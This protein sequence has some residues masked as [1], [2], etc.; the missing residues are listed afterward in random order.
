MLANPSN[1]PTPSHP[2]N[3]LPRVQ[4]R[5]VQAGERR[6]DRFPTIPQRHQWLECA[7][8]H[9]SHQLVLRTILLFKAPVVDEE[10]FDSYV[11]VD[12]VVHVAHAVVLLHGQLVLRDGAAD[13]DSAP[14]ICHAN[15]GLE[16]LA[17]NVLERAIETAGAYLR[18]RFAQVCGHVR[19]VVTVEDGIGAE[20]SQQTQLIAGPRRR[21]HLDTALLEELDGHRAHRAGCTRYV[22]H[23]AGLRFANVLDAEVG[24]DS[25]HPERS[26]KGGHK[27]TRSCVGKRGEL[28]G[29]QAQPLP[30]RAIKSNQLSGSAACAA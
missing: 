27:S 14:S 28:K 12:E 22:S 3:E 13:D 17:A 6:R 11:V 18:K 10:A 23:L 7:G 16:C 29:L 5:G 25:G 20:P 4:P 8:F 21:D 24:G 19:A 2:H 1:L 30:P 26:D 15:R 9:Q